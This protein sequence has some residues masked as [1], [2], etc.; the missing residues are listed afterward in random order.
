M[1]RDISDEDEATYEKVF[2]TAARHSA[3]YCKAKGITELASATLEARM[4][5]GV[6]GQM[7]TLSLR[8]TERGRLLLC[9]ADNPHLNTEA[10]SEATYV[11][12]ITEEWHE[13]LIDLMRSLQMPKDEE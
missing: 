3:A 10:G 1:V 13:K 8:E 6:K 7:F 12:H 11:C 4:R 5:M 2:E 9:I